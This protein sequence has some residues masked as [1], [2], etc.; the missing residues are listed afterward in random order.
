MQRATVFAPLLVGLLLLGSS[1]E[2]QDWAGRGR[3]Q[4]IVT[5][6]DRNPIAGAKVTLY[7]NAEGNGPKPLIT[8]K[9]GRWSTLGLATGTWTVLI[10]AEG[11]KIAEG[12]ARVLSEGIGPGETLR[13]S[14]NPIPKELIEATKAESPAGM[15]ERG[16]ALMMERKFAEARAEYEK[17]IAAIE[18]TASHPAILRG[19][20]RTYYEEGKKAEAME[21]LQRALTVAPDDQDS[22]KLIVTILLND[23][24]EA[25]AAPYKAR[26]TGEFKVDPNSLLNLG[27]QKFNE[28]KTAEALVY[29]EQVVADNPGLPDGYYYRGLCYLNQNKTAEAKADFQKLLEL[30]PNHPRAAEA[31]DFLA[32]L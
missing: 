9:K 17:A 27:I 31:K 10:E 1:V 29:F 20:V 22:L 24:K 26:I 5:D 12:A 8:D 6:Q 7:L 32:A 15:I 11:F 25:E 13:V 4:G 16:N 3:L 28:G 19:I 21:T 14:L 2:A 30:D 23:G 18:D